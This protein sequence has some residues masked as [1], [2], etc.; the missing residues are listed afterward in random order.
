M[1]YRVY[2]LR[3]GQIVSTL[4][5]RAHGATAAEALGTLYDEWTRRGWAGF[6]DVGQ[7]YLVVSVHPD[8]GIAQNG[9]ALFRL[10]EV[11]RHEFVPVSI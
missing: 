10:E 11:P 8:G 3:D 9:Q 1:Y 4:T 7:Q 6:K 5:S 2:K